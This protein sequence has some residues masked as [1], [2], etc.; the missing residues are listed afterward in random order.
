MVV[1]LDATQGRKLELGT[2][3]VMAWPGLAVIP[4]CL[5]AEEQN[6]YVKGRCLL[7]T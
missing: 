7:G 6:W 3:T 1:S 5:S 4:P 2:K